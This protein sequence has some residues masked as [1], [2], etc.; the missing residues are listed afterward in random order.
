LR[1]VEIMLIGTISTLVRAYLPKSVVGVPKFLGGA[2][3]VIDLG[4][5]MRYRV[6]ILTDRVLRIPDVSG[7]FVAAPR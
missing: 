5:A 6:A 3:R 2:V 1:I 4:N 7:T